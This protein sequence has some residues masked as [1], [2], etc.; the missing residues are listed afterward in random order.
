MKSE[1]N[2]N[3]EN[4]RMDDDDL[5]H[6]SPEVRA[7]VLKDR[8]NQLRKLINLEGLKRYTQELKELNDRLNDLEECDEVE[9]QGIA[10][11]VGNA[12]MRRHYILEL[13]LQLHL[14]L[15]FAEGYP[16]LEAELRPVA[17]ELVDL[18]REIQTNWGVAVKQWTPKSDGESILSSAA[19]FVTNA[20]T[21]KRSRILTVGKVVVAYE[22][23]GA[24]GHDE[25][26]EKLREVLTASPDADLTALE[27]VLQIKTVRVGG[28]DDPG[29]EPYDMPIG[30]KSR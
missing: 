11:E 10:G 17:G 16:E 1:E 3:E 19:Q 8:E 23:R 15:G 30:S 13:L 22:R 25:I 28:K 29:F 12:Q 27:H 24:M 20:L 6:L 21:A 9:V 26:E 5:S 4:E 7:A 2:A 14:G 18:T